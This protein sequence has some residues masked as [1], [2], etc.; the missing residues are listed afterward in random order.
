MS[1][2][3]PQTSAEQRDR[4]LALVAAGRSFSDVAAE[5][6]GNARLRGRVERIVRRESRTARVRRRWTISSPS[7]WPKSHSL[8]RTRQLK[9][10]RGWSGSCLRG[11]TARTRRAKSLKSRP[12]CEPNAWALAAEPGRHVR[13]T[14]E[15]AQRWIRRPARECSCDLRVMRSEVKGDHVGSHRRRCSSFGSH[16]A[17]TSCSRM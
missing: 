10:I 5:V 2:P 14:Y 11:R 3:P 6:F 1:G 13:A 4:V 17:S 7:S 15:L 16:P 12:G 8:W 9:L